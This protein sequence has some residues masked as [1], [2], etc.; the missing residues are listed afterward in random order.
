VPHNPMVRQ[1]VEQGHFISRKQQRA[2]RGP[3]ENGL[4]LRGAVRFDHMAVRTHPT[5]VPAAAGE[6]PT[7]RSGD[8]RPSTAVAREA[9]G[10][11][12]AH[13]AARIGEEQPD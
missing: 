7:C 12:Q 8:S 1:F 5:G 3:A 11:P 9:F 13:D 6:N 4:S 10:G 2:D